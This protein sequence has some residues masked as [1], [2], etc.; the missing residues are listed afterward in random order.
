MYIGDGAGV[1][2]KLDIAGTVNSTGNFYVGNDGVGL[3]NVLDGGV[4][5]LKGFGTTT[6]TSS[7]TLDILGEGMVISAGSQVNNANTLIAGG[8]IAGDG[9]LG[10]VYAYFDGTNTIIAVVPEPATM[11]LLGLGG[12]L[13]RK[14][15]R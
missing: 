8:R 3:C 15:R 7:S 4:L 2:G 10:D 6:I 9:V 13:L 5:N 14:R 12:L 11:I 1:T